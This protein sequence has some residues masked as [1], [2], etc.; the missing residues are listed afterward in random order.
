MYTVPKYTSYSSQVTLSHLHFLSFSV[1]QNPDPRKS[2][3]SLF[4]DVSSIWDPRQTSV[5][6]KAGRWLVASHQRCKRWKSA[7]LGISRP[8]EDDLQL[9]QP[10]STLITDTPNMLSSKLEI[11]ED[12]TKHKGVEWN[13]FRE[14]DTSIAYSISQQ[15]Q[16]PKCLS[17][18]Q[19]MSWWA[20]LGSNFRPKENVARRGKA[21][22]PPSRSPCLRSKDH[23]GGRW[24]AQIRKKTWLWNNFVKIKKI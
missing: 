14:V 7:S 9:I 15:L 4:L 19:S 2:K 24:G 22:C 12:N 11:K 1:H 16:S 17:H 8:G 20:N 3:V 13:V 6:L 23:P 18:L 10:G 5:A 21:Q